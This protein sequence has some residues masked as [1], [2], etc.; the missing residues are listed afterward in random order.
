MRKPHRVVLA[1]LA[2]TAAAGTVIASAVSG[3]GNPRPDGDASFTTVFKN[4]QGL[5][6]LTAD[7]EGNVYSAERGEKCEV[8]RVPAAGGAAAVVGFLPTPCSPAGI[9]F[10]PDGRLYAADTDRVL[11]LAPS[12]A[13]PQVATVYASGVPGTN[14]LAFDRDGNLW[15]GDGGTAQGRVWRIGSDGA[16]T[17]VFRVQPMANSFG[18]GR[19]ANSLPPGTPQGIVANGLAFTRDGSLLVADTARGAIWRVDL[20]RRGELMSPT[21]CDTTFTANTLCLDNIWVQHVYL[22]GNDGIV[23]DR[24]GNVWSAANERNAIVVVSKKGTVSEFFRNEPDAATKLR[25]GGPMEF[26][27]SPVF[28]EGRFCVTSSDGGRRDNSPNSAGEV[29]PGTA[30]VAKISCLAGPEQ[31]DEE[32]DD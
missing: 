19:T 5:E 28:A 6:G 8:W 21:G 2:A 3:S 18:V 30:F 9:T 4:P 7:A 11:A 27:T 22:E 32:D 20:S 26:P 25:N 14:G 15:T 31:N 1:M 13:A 24:S 29:A 16:A 10:G 17:E 23:L 12:E